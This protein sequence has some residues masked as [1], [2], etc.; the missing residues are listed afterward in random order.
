[1]ESTEKKNY[2]FFNSEQYLNQY[3]VR[4]YKITECHQLMHAQDYMQIWYVKNGEC[5][6]WIKHTEYH[7]K[8]GDIAIL[9]SFVFHRLDSNGFQNLVLFGCDFLESFIYS[10]SESMNRYLKQSLIG[11][12]KEKA[13]YRLNGNLKKE[14]ESLFERMLLE[15]NHK[16]PCFELVIKSCIFQIFS[17]LSRESDK[18]ED[19]RKS[20]LMEFHRANI[21]KAVDYIDINYR[22]KITLAEVSKI[23]MMSSTY[24]A[25]I[26][27]EITGRTFTEYI[28]YLRIQNAIE[29]M[30]DRRISLKEI[31][32]NIGLKDPAYFSRVFKKQMGV[33]PEKYRNMFF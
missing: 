9:P 31:A 18:K 17:M 5:S 2:W 27:K 28:N 23:T 11:N 21:M 25:E 30:K 7:L 1:M 26:F 10:N 32:E 33:S 16:K 3:P 8:K 20:K 14:A 24:F 15:F 19:E 4:I 22:K 12:Y 13:F 29:L 6:Y